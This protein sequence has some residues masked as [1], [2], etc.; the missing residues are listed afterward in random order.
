V[1]V[2]SDVAALRA[3]DEHHEVLVARVRD[4]ARG[5]RGHVDDAARPEQPLFVV[6]LDARRTGVHEVEL[7]LLVVVVEDA[8]VM[9]RH[10]DHVDTERLDAERLSHLSEPVPL[11]ELVDRSERVRHAVAPFVSSSASMVRRRPSSKLTT[12]S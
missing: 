10:H 8:V 11:A 2:A 4:A 6:H 3:D 7:V 9:G 1:A 5:R 12:G